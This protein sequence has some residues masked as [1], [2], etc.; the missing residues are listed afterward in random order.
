MTR[1]FEFYPSFSRDGQWIVYTTW[2]DADSGRVRVV[3]AD[4]SGGRDV[5]TRRGHYTEP[6][7]S[8]DGKTIVFRHVG[9]DQI[10]GPLLRRRAR[11]LRRPGC[12]RRAAARARRRRRAGVRSHR[13][14][15]LSPRSPEREVRALQR[16]RAFGDR[17]VPGRDEIEH[18]RSDNATQYAPSPD[19]KW[20]AFEERFRT[21]VA[22]FPRTGR[23]V[24]IGPGTQSYPVQRVSRDAGFYLHWSGD[25]TR[26]SLGARPGA[27]HARDL[28]RTFT[29]V[30]GAQP[31]PDEPEAKG[32]P[33]GFTASADV[34]EG[35]IALVGARIITARSSGRRA[36]TRAPPTSSRTAPSSSKA[37]ASPPSARQRPCRSLP[38]RGVSTSRARR[39]CP[40]SS[41][42]TRTWAANPAVCW[43]RRAGR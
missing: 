17:A 38:A 43:P 27:L 24:D 12:R 22:P 31:K 6:S 23:P 28:G 8:P 36:G 20:I 7:F 14:A 16:R 40:A 25:S 30:E 11:R 13:H 33:I 15:H 3:R 35:S 1:P 26:L 41:T 9:G 34:P 4:G 32:T 5:V 2:S 37:T 10:R 39:S 18:V 29:F 19:G 42:C 21:F